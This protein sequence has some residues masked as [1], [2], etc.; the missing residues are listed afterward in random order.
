MR[1]TPYRVFILAPML[2]L[3]ASFGIQR[4]ARASDTGA[5][6]GGILAGALVYELLNDDDHG[7]C[8]HTYYYGAPGYYRPSYCPPPYYGSGYYYGYAYAPPV[9]EYRYY[10]TR[11]RTYVYR[12][13]DGA[14]YNQRAYRAPSHAQRN[15]GPPPGYQR[16]GGKYA[17]PAHYRR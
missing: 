12:D 7:Y 17:P 6:I 15:V 14:R 8:G 4:A 13:Y 3:A 5:V 9:I 1:S 10:D 11:P 16:S 2:V